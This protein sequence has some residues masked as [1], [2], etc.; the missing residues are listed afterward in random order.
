MACKIKHTGYFRLGHRIHVEFKPN[1]ISVMVTVARIRIPTP[2]SCRLRCE[3]KEVA[4]HDMSVEK[5]GVERRMQ[6]AE[7]ASVEA[8]RLLKNKEDELSAA[9]HALST[10]NAAVATQT[11]VAASAVKA[12]EEAEGHSPPFACPRSSCDLTISTL[13]R[14]RMRVAF[15]L[16]GSQDTTKV[17]R[18]DW[19]PLCFEWQQ[20]THR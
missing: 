1:G 8:A 3:E 7:G 11:E 6:S 10:A 12:K 5:D 19:T 14:Y 15:F 9:T 16:P 17:K 13:E 4:L 20:M 2:N 18:F